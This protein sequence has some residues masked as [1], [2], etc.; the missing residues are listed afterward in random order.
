MTPSSSSVKKLIEILRKFSLTSR[1]SEWVGEILDIYLWELFQVNNIY[2]SRNY[3]LFLGYSGKALIHNI[4]INSILV[5][6]I[7][8]IFQ[9]L[10]INFMYKEF[11]LRIPQ[12]KE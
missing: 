7:P 9:L 11:Y 6:I 2:Y 12:K 1:C 10:G 4:G 3:L 8:C 5:S